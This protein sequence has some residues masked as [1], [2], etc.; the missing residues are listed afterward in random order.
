MNHESRGDALA[1]RANSNA[2]DRA[3]HMSMIAEPKR[4]RRQ[5]TPSHESA[6][7]RVAGT[8][9][10]LAGSEDRLGPRDAPGTRDARRNRWAHAL[11]NCV[12]Y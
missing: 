12:R 1:A 6:V 3:D 2:S 5:L 7:V 8:L 9:Q 11:R 4:D 10:E